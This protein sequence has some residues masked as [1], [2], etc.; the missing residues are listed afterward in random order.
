V[1]DLGISF[2]V[3][4][5]LLATIPF[6]GLFWSWLSRRLKHLEKASAR[7]ERL[8]ETALQISPAFRKAWI[9]AEL[10]RQIAQ[11]GGTGGE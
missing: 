10:L 3:D 11:K 4:P 9:E 2:T 7:Y 5:F 1:T 8:F 6:G